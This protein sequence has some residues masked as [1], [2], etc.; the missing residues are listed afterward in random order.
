MEEALG[1]DCQSNDGKRK[2]NDSTFQQEERKNVWNSHGLVHPELLQ[3]AL[4]QMSDSPAPLTGMYLYIAIEREKN[5]GTDFPS[6]PRAQN[7]HS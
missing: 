6:S 4:C 1:I 5:E 2:S 7:Q 3:T